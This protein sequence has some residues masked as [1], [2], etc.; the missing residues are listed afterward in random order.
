MDKPSAAVKSIRERRTRGRGGARAFLAWGALVCFAVQLSGCGAPSGPRKSPAPRG[1]SSAPDG[2][3]AGLP[4][5]S[6]GGPSNDREDGRVTAIVLGSDGKP[7]AGV[8]CWLVDP[9]TVDPARAVALSRTL[10]DWVAASRGIASE[11]ARS[12]ADGTVRF[13]K[14][15]VGGFLVAAQRGADFGMAERATRTDQTVP[16]QMAARA[17]Y[18]VEVRTASGRPAGEVPVTLAAPDPGTPK[19]PYLLPSTAVT[20][21]QGIATLYE[22]PAAAAANILEGL[23]QVSERLAVVRMPQKSLR[24]TSLRRD[25]SVR[26]TLPPAAALE[27]RCEHAAFP[28]DHFGGLVQVFPAADGSRSERT[29]A[30][31]MKDGVLVVPYAEAGLD[32]RVVAVLTESDRP[33]RFVGTILQDARMPR[34]AD[35][36]A[37]CVLRLDGGLLVTGRCVDAAGA[38][39]ANA[40]ID[41]FVV[42]DPGSSWTVVTDTEGRFRWLLQRE[43]G[44]FAQRVIGLRRKHDGGDSRASVRLGDLQGG[45]VVD[46]GE[47]VVK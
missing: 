42:G 23:D 9:Q 38:S 10:G 21:A 16:I 29:L 5:S 22:P 32:L 28:S 35:V 34:T 14:D 31:T 25:E 26:V 44:D 41:V 43:D 2:S 13:S 45:Q 24:P 4:G 36:R 20:D 18:R 15:T 46:L 30:A 11:T 6:S 40:P 8:E 12:S 27:I 3:S 17:T 1:A 39:L 19:K 37:D 7:A 33:E 47:V